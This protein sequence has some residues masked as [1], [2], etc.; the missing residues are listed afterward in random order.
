[1]VGVRISVLVAALV[2]ALLAT[3]APASADAYIANKTVTDARHWT[4]EVYSPSMNRTV[5]VQ[6]QLAARRH[7]PVLYLLNGAGGGEDK[8]TWA[9][10]TDVDDFL[11]DKDVNV[12]TPIGGAF[13]YYADWVSPDPKLGV[14][15]WQT[16]LSKELPPLLDAALGTSG[17]NAVAG[18]STSG[19]AVLN[20]VIHNAGRYQAAAAYSGCAQTADPF[21][22]QAIDLVL[23]RGGG[24]IDNMYGPPD[25]PRW[26]ANDP[27]LHADKLRGTALYLSTGSGFPGLH[28]RPGDPFIVPGNTIENQIVVGGIIEAATN[29]C[30]HNLRTQLDRL[31]IPATYNFRPGTHSWGYW[32]EDFKASWP[33]LAGAIG[34]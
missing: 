18:I 27:Y 24:T 29:F 22:R 16:F 3:P 26:A 17:R 30:T 7:S 12:V 2:A 21:G 11:A 20:L 5:P 19:T 23:S 14:N 9:Q 25:D 6:V 31:G 32:Q 13:T 4:L 28:D 1:M 8:A 34:A 10:N 33:V 15:K